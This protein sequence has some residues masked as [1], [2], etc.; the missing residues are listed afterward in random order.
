MLKVTATSN[1]LL[2]AMIDCLEDMQ[3]MAMAA[4]DAELLEDASA[5]LAKTLV[6]YCDARRDQLSADIAQNKQTD[7]PKAG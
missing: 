2:A 4:G 7:L 1:E 6:K 5:M 3:Q